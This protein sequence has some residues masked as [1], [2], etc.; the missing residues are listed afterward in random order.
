[1]CSLCLIEEERGRRG[2]SSVSWM[3]DSDRHGARGQGGAILMVCLYIPG[4]EGT[5][6]MNGGMMKA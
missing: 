5:E 6:G 2:H 4:G 1:M 3:K